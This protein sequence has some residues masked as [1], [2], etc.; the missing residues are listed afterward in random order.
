MF[1]KD[2]FIHLDLGREL[3]FLQLALPMHVRHHARTLLII[4]HENQP[5][6]GIKILGPPVKVS[7][8]LQ[9]EMYVEPSGTEGF[10]KKTTA[11]NDLLRSNMQKGYCSITKS[12]FLDT[13][14]EHNNWL[15]EDLTESVNLIFATLHTTPFASL[16]LKIKVMTISHTNKWRHL[17]V[18][19]C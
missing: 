9:D 17:W 2:S 6:D 14:E 10:N 18:G 11:V 16:I 15:E 1:G 19:V 5:L 8:T 13:A 12:A 7:E 4:R 3:L